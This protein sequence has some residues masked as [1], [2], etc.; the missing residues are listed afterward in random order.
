VRG[1]DHV[2]VEIFVTVISTSDGRDTYGG[3]FDAELVEHFR[4]ESVDY[5]VR[6]AGTIM[7]RFIY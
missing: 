1:L 3:S 5:S 4:H 2:A 7:K 6:A